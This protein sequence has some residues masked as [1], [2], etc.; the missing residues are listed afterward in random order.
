MLGRRA[1]HIHVFVALSFFSLC[2]CVCT[3][4]SPN[5]FMKDLS[6][7]LDNSYVAA[8]R[9]N[10]SGNEREHEQDLYG[11]A[12]NT[13]IGHSGLAGNTKL[14]NELAIAIGGKPKLSVD[15]KPVALVRKESR[16]Q[17]AARAAAPS[18]LF[19][20]QPAAQ[21]DSRFARNK[22]STVKLTPPSQ[23]SFTSSHQGSQLIFSGAISHLLPTHHQAEGQR[24]ITYAAGSH[25]VEDSQVIQR[26]KRIRASLTGDIFDEN[27]SMTPISKAAAMTARQKLMKNSPS[28]HSLIEDSFELDW[29]TPT[30]KKAL[31]ANYY[32]RVEE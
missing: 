18:S 31:T 30:T 8:R 4:L 14:R 10:P 19:R 29:N 24:E 17:K 22:L 16:A 2:H 25:V 5:K 7:I 6:T 15:G 28:A 12:S 26:A 32:C 20:N 9:A 13:L 1:P 11:L 23:G 21:R 27:Q 3:A